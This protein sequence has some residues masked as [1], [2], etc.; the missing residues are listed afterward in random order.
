M[1]WS[2]EFKR[3]QQRE[4]LI[5]NSLKVRVRSINSYAV[6]ETF[7]TD[8]FCS[9]HLLEVILNPTHKS[10]KWRVMSLSESWEINAR[11]SLSLNWDNCMLVLLYE[12]TISALRRTKIFVFF[13]AIYISTT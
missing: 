2:R 11:K 10:A 8:G 12:H 7:E 4:G 5:M 1:P 13:P 6:K 3:N 9:F